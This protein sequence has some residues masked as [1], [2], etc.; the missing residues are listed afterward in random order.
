[1]LLDEPISSVDTQSIIVF[2][3][4]LKSMSETGV[5]VLITTH[6]LDFIFNLCDTVAILYDKKIVMK[7]RLANFKKNQLEN[8]YLKIIGVNVNASVEKFRQISARKIKAIE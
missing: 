4:L 6:I 7:R 2:K 3:K 8:V 1:M 5:T